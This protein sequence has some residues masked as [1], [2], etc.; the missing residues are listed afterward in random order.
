MTAAHDYEDM[1]WVLEH[2]TP[3]QVRR[4]RLIISQDAELAP[5]VEALTEQAAQ[6]EAAQAEEVPA[7]LL[8]LIGSVDTGRTDGAENHDEYIRERMR[9]RRERWA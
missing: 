4:L 8:A 6:A 3:P 5:V 1:R 7:D 9:R 2:L